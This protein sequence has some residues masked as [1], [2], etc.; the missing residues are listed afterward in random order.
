MSDEIEPGAPANE[1]LKPLS[2]GRIL[3]L[4]A[5]IGLAGAIVGG[6]FVSTAFGA[7]VIIG[8]LLAFVN[9]YWLK[10]SLNKVFSA[11]AES[12]ERPRFLGLKYIGRYL[13][14][15]AIVAVLYATGAVSIVG[16]ILGMGSFGFAVVFEGLFNI[17][18]R[19]GKQGE[20]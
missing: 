10:H 12:G 4:M 17:F 14:I 2:H 7:G 11:A 19:P 16:L 1:T 20:S 9:Y 6:I 13:V 18:F 15:A 8:T 5:L 3:K